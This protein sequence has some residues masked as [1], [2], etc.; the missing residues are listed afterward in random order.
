M[1]HGHMPSEIAGNESIFLAHKQQLLEFVIE[2][3]V[4]FGIVVAAAGDQLF[5]NVIFKEFQ[6]LKS[7]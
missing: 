1:C 7:L 4:L 2:C 6:N 5:Q 3:D